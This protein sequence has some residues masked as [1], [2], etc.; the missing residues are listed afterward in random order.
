MPF[1]TLLSL[2]FSFMMKSF[3]PSSTS[4]V[5][6]KEYVSLLD[7]DNSSSSSECVLSRK[8]ADQLKDLIVFNGDLGSLNMSNK[9]EDVTERDEHHHGKIETLIKANM[10]NFNVDAPAVFQEAFLGVSTVVKRR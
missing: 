1:F 6:C 9:H 2:M 8:Y 10:E 5:V 3:Y 4:S 7:S